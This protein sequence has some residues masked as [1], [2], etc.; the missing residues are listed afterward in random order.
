MNT[1][2]TEGVKITV[3]T[4]FRADLSQVNESRFFFNYRIEMENM[5]ESPVQLIHR[6]W[7]IFD[8][9]NEPNIVSG[10]GVIGE[11]PILKPGQTYAYTSGCE[12]TSELGR[13]RGFYTFQNQI[14]G[15]M[16]QILIPTFDLVYPAKLN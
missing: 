13:M 16:L 15:E 8:S 10:Q 7:Y 1:I 4:R 6:D 2:T 11:Q 3:T 9:L 14:S 12:L 5:K